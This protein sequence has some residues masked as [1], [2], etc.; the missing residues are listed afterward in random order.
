MQEALTK[1]P[2]QSHAQA[3]DHKLALFPSR[4]SHGPGHQTSVY[5]MSS[6][7][8]RLLKAAAGTCWPCSFVFHH[9]SMYSGHPESFRLQ[10]SLP[11]KPTAT[12][13]RHETEPWQKYSEVMLRN[14]MHASRVGSCHVT[15]EP[16]VATSVRALILTRIDCK[17]TRWLEQSVPDGTD[18]PCKTT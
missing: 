18:I 6:S 2:A 14:G 12:P 15:R 16:Q 4:H 13:Q 11:S 17:H 8:E 9:L 5:I 10:T 3:P 1:A 7:E